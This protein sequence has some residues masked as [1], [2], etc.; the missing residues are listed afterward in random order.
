MI[1]KNIIHL[2]KKYIWEK[3]K[4][5]F[6]KK[7]LEY[8]GPYQLR[9]IEKGTPVP[10]PDYNEIPVFFVETDDK[11][12]RGMLEVNFIEYEKGK[13]GQYFNKRGGVIVCTQKM[14]CYYMSKY[15]NAKRAIR[16]AVNWAR[17]RFILVGILILFLINTAMVVIMSFL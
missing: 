16:K 11:R 17:F 13:V 1:L 10:A 9:I 8:R 15:D 5:T 2:D 14:N 3:M 7:N 4:N 6:R 12:Y